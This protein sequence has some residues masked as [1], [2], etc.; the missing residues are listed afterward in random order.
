MTA[1]PVRRP[2]RALLPDLRF[3][4]NVEDVTARHPRPLL[5]LRAGIAQWAAVNHDGTVRTTDDERRGIPPGGHEVRSCSWTS[6]WDG[7]AGE[8]DSFTLTA[9]AD[10]PPGWYG[11]HADFRQPFT[12]NL[13]RAEAMVTVLRRAGTRLRRLAGQFG[14]PAGFAGWAAR[15]YAAAGGSLGRPFGRRPGRDLDGSGYQWMDTDGLRSWLNSQLA[16]FC[17]AHS[18]TSGQVR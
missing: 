3:L 9:Q 18:L 7:V 15:I 4:F 5:T 16:A 1:T 13:P 8:W 10:S 6:R 2:A 17:H 11:Y 12:V 14:Q